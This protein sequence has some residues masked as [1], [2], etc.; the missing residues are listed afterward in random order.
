MSTILIME[1]DEKNF[2][3][4][5]I[6]LQSDTCQVLHATNGEDGIRLAQAHH[7]DLIVI[8]MR[9]PKLTGWDIISILK[10]NSETMSIPAIAMSAITEPNVHQRAVE[11]G[12]ELFIAKPFTVQQL[13]STIRQFAPDC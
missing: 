13:R 6:I 9:M 7:P 10:A 8:D 2:S 12:F 1:D 11:A 5:K 3:L 4:I